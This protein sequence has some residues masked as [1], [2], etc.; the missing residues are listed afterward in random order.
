MSYYTGYTVKNSK[1]KPVTAL[2]PLKALTPKIVTPWAIVLVLVSLALVSSAFLFY[3]YSQA[4]EKLNQV[5]TVNNQDNNQDSPKKI[6]EAVAKI[7]VLPTDQT[8]TIATVTKVEKLRLTQP[9]FNAA[10][11]GDKLLI[12]TDKAVLYRPDENKIVAIG[13]VN[14]VAEA[15]PE[16]EVKPTLSL[17]ATRSAR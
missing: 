12:F 13:P 3:K 7:M 8:P 2:L 10:E 16:A 15:S 6:L 5:V 17:E 14:Q 11:N 9:F 4:Q 1:P